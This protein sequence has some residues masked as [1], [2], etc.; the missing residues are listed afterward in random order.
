MYLKLVHE[1]TQDK[2]HYII[3]NCKVQDLTISLLITLE[4]DKIGSGLGVPGG[5][6]RWGLRDG[7]VLGMSGLT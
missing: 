6:A 7:P 2:H 4:Q 1:T 3:R 5:W